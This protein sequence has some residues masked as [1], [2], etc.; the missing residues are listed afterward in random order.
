MSYFATFRE[1]RLNSFLLYFKIKQKCINCY[2]NLG[3]PRFYA[4]KSNSDLKNPWVTKVRIYKKNLWL[5][6]SLIQF[7]VYQ[8]LFIH[9]SLKVDK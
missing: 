4:N 8:Y 1:M 9:L 7:C 2:K 5:L 6:R 3:N